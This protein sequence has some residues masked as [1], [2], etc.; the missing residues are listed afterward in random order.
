MI[1]AQVI[2]TYSC[3]FSTAQRKKKEDTEDE[4]N[5]MVQWMNWNNSFINRMQL[6]LL[7]EKSG[8]IL[9]VLVGLKTGPQVIW[10]AVRRNT[11]SFLKIFYRSHR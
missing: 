5:T 8:A 6:H 3:E 4:R 7:C 11:G 10:Q 2:D 9:L 1:K